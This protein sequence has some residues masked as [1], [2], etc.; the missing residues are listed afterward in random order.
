MKKRALLMV[1]LFILP[2]YGQ[3]VDYNQYT[4]LDLEFEL[5]SQ[6]SLYPTSMNYAL[7]Y[8]TANLTFYPHGFANQ[9]IISLSA[10]STPDVE[11]VMYAN[12]IYYNWK[13]P[14]INQFSYRI[15][16]KIRN[17]N[18]I[19]KI[20]EKIRIINTGNE[21]TKASEFIDIND[22]IRNKAA[23][24]ANG[25]DDLYVIAFK[26]ADWV[27]NNVD[28]NLS[29]LTADVVQPS[30]WV[31]KNREGVCDELTNLFISMMR[32]LGIPAK[33]ISGVAYTNTKNSWG[34]HAW[35]EV[36]FPDKGWVPFDITYKQFGWIDPTHIKLMESIDSGESSVKYNYKSY[37]ME[38]KGEEIELNT[39]LLKTGER[40]APLAILDIEPL[41]NNVGAGSYVPV[42]IS[43]RNLKD[44]YLPE[45][46]Y[47]VKSPGLTEKN[48]KSILLKPNQ[49]SRL[50]WIVEIP[51][52]A[53]NDYMY[54]TVIE[55]QDLFHSTASDVINYAY[56]YK[57]IS[58]NEAQDIIKK[59]VVEEVNTYSES[60][61]I[62]CSSNK[63]Y[64][65]E[66]EAG[67]IKCL[68]ENNDEKTVS[69]NACMLDDC[70]S[71]SIDK[72]G[73]QEARFALKN[74]PD[75]TEKVKIGVSNNE[76]EVNDYVDVMVL[77]SPEL[78]VSNLN[79]PFKLDYNEE[80]NLEFTLS[81][82]APVKY[83]LIGV[84]GKNVYEIQNF[85]NQQKLSVPSSGKDFAWN[86]HIIIELDYYDE[87]GK[88]YKE[89]RAYPIEIKNIPFYIKML[90]PI[91]RLF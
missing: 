38:F 4:T 81:S 52:R 86:D 5:F 68:L 47:I 7:E 25:E 24:L 71:I 32:T 28:Y 3:E 22:D 1:L 37:N 77:K 23:E 85:N 62:T 17:I 11:P 10:S 16:S 66:Y 80:F 87:N 8:V 64:Y 90:K 82:K 74:L 31:F 56:N 45:T 84:N 12:S 91:T 65:F 39:R 21:Y 9:K 50:F 70:K 58:L 54:S 79:N 29:T 14:N 27:E 51:K 41:V 49:D 44:H 88:R 63:R 26:I 2:V 60:I 55:V 53:E 6:F 59:I 34:P 72:D 40:I 15:N 19:A 83:A 75:F 20:E 61:D 36:Y 48:S 46:L 78:R 73:R 33:F 69:L 42:E 18:T 67:E 89:K 30:S 35:A 76:I 57:I 13:K 43:I